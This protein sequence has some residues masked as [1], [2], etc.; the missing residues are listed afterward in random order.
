MFD[1]VFD[2]QEIASQ[3]NKQINQDDLVFKLREVR[4][5]RKN[6][7]ILKNMLIECGRKWDTSV[8][9]KRLIAQKIAKTYN[10]KT[11]DSCFKYVNRWLLHNAIAEIPEDV[12]SEDFVC[13]VLYDL[14]EFPLEQVL[15][16]LKNE[17]GAILNLD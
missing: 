17:Y 1:I 2:V 16:R 6:Q 3:I 5:A 9:S 12:Y 8:D 4:Q 14:S 15:Y 10:R 11:V 7:R 13:Q